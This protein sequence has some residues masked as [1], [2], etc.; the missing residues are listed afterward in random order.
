MGTFNE[1]IQQA[2]NNINF[3]SEISTNIQNCW[4]WQVT[5]CFYSAL[6]LINSHIVKK[7][8]SNYLT[9]SRVEGII[10]PFNQLSVARLD[11]NTYTSYIKLF[12]LSRRS[13]YL[14]SENFKKAGKIDV[15]NASMTY[16][17]HLKKA[18]HHLEVIINF[19]KSEYQISFPKVN[20]KCIDLKDIAFQNF[21]V[22]A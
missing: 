5:V 6:H 17:K 3:L 2:K 4:D 1:H 19:V 16:S 9:H 11:E 12:Q 18:V 8:N 14:L 10:N 21:S 22:T 7:T 20:L 13:R 15:Q